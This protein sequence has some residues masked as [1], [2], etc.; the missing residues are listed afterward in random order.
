MLFEGYKA[1]R[2][3]CFLKNSLIFFI[4]FL[5]MLVGFP[6]GITRK[7]FKILQ[8]LRCVKSSGAGFAGFRPAL[9]GLYSGKAHPPPGAL[10][11][12]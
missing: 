11:Y 5:V 3:L 7:K 10:P 4:V 8:F 9:E 12:T 2:A 1:R 6:P